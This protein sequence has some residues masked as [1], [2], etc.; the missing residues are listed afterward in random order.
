M[1]S[2]PTIVSLSFC[3]EPRSS[4]SR[5]S[6]DCPRA[7]A[8]SSSEIL[9]LWDLTFQQFDSQRGEFSQQAS[10]TGVPC[11]P[12]ALGAKGGLLVRAARVYRVCRSKGVCMEQSWH[13]L[14]SWSP[15]GVWSLDAQ[16][17]LYGLWPQKQVHRFPT[18]IQFLVL[19]FTELSSSGS[20]ICS[21]LGSE[22]LGTWD[23]CCVA[24]DFRSQ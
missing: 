23:G 13:D 5:Q 19:G 18:W 14:W 6:S 20:R 21:T 9:I 4:S 7:S 3:P 11:G 10:S 12:C 8:T 17:A 2:L 22:A 16:C 24:S 15:H 1:W